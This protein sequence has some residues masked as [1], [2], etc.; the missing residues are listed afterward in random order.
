M[1][2]W[3]SWEDIAFA[4]SKDGKLNDFGI[5]K[6]R[7]VN[8]NGEAIPIFRFVGIDRQGLIYVGRSGYRSQKTG[9]TIANR[10]REFVKQQHSGGITY[11]R[12]EKVLER[13]GKFFEHRLQVRAMF[14]PDEE[15][16]R[17]EKKVLRDYFSQYAELPPCNSAF[18]KDT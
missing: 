5:Y 18:P 9:R 2:N 15:I 11:A 4:K 16:D 13:E 6:I 12:A 17:T 10:I 3:S 1:G 7:V 14:L 8:R